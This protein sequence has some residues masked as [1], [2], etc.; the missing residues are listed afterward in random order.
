MSGGGF[1]PFVVEVGR[2][3]VEIRKPI[4]CLPGWGNEGIV[5]LFSLG[6]QGMPR[7][8]RRRTGETVF[9]ILTSDSTTI[10]CSSNSNANFSFWGPAVPSKATSVVWTWRTNLPAAA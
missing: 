6:R 7:I 3:R 2:V 9:G 4:G 5:D 1:L 8:V 10:N